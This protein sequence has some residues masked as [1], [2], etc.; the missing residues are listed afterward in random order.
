MNTARGSELISISP[1][2]SVGRASHWY[3][4]GLRFDSGCDHINLFL[5]PL[6]PT[7]SLLKIDP[8][9]F[10]FLF[11]FEQKEDLKLWCSQGPGKVLRQF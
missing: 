1:D 11:F 6:T 9:H 8:L 10:F 5:V 2:S 3:R 4:E 7:R